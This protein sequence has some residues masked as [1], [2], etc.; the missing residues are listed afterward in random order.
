[1]DQ[2]ESPDFENFPVEKLAYLLRQFYG[3]ARKKN[4]DHYGRSALI[5]LRA[6]LNRHITSPPFNRVLNLMHDREFQLANQ[7]LVGALRKIK[8]EGRDKTQHK[9]S[10]SKDDMAKL[11]SSSATVQIQK[12]QKVCSKKF[13]ST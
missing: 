9:A 8:Q 1:M 11:Y 10:V 2:N 3:D 4:G 5:N 13:L 7:L 6:G 12:L